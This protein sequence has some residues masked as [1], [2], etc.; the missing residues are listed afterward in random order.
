MRYWIATVSKAH[1]LR[2]VA[3]GFC[4]VCHGKAAPL[5]RMANGDGLLYYSPTLHMGDSSKYQAFTA[6][7]HICDDAPYP[8]QM[9]A[10]FI[11]YRRNVRY[12]D[13]RRECPLAIARAHP[14]WKSYA[15]R[16]RY[17]HFEIAEDFFRY[18]AAHMC[19]GDPLR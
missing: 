4:Q 15:S 12:A 19:G 17:G 7:G 18:I 9:T 14:E 1:V 2:G 11:P 3:G 13:I 5:A 6:L 10:D 8:F 16:L